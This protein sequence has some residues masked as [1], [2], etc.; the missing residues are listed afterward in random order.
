MFLLHLLILFIM[1]FGVLPLIILWVVLVIL[2]FLLMISLNIHG[3][4]LCR[5][6]LSY[7]IFIC[8]L[9]LWLKL[10]FLLQLKFFSTDNAMEYRDSVLT[11]FFSQNGTIIH[12]SC[13]GTS[14]QNGRA[15]RKHRHILNTTRAFLISFFCPEIF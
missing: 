6:N 9:P 12:R 13:P 14:Q 8:N 5:I 11:Q 10:S 4:I 15:E 2:W 7:L 1:I 3:F